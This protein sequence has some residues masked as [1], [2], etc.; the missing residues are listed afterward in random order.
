MSMVD[1]LVPGVS[2]L[3]TFAHYYSLYWSIAALAEENELGSVECRRVI[4]RAEAAMAVLSLA[5][6]DAQWRA[7]GGDG[8]LKALDGGFDD[9]VES[10]SPRAWG[11]WSQYNGPSTTLGITSTN[12]GALR[13]GRHMCPAEVREMF[14]PLHEA[15]GRTAVSIDEIENLRQLAMHEA[16]TPDVAF[17]RTL[18]AAS[19]GGPHDQEEWSGDDRTRRATL[20]LLARAAQLHPEVSEHSYV[21]AFW[22]AVAYGVELQQDPVLAGIEHAPVWRGVLLRSHSVGAWRRL[23]SD[24]VAHVRENQVATREDLHGWISAA[25]PT[26]SVADFEA[27]LPPVENGEGHPLPAEEQA[28]ADYTGPQAEVAVLLLGATRLDALSVSEKAGFL[29]RGRRQFLD[30]NWVAAR[31]HDYWSRPLRDLGRILV[32]DMLAQSRRVAMRKIEISRAGQMTLF[33]RLHER[34]GVYFAQSNEGRGNVGLRI[35]QLAELA[36]QVGLL[37]FDGHVTAAGEELLDVRG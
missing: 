37:S 16:D 7:H 10:Y 1:L 11:F 20:R 25:L 24:L 3:T 15:A 32:D 29:G 6:D 27:S 9:V 36:H 12:T 4:R 18:F 26:G 13:G 33:A 19:R 2:T 22:Q 35:A 21:D 30:P 31:S 28:R 14:R 8:A 17:L 23:W 5:N 34:D